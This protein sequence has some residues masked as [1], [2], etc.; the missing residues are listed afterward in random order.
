LQWTQEIIKSR[1]VLKR[2]YV[3]TRY[4]EATMG[5]VVKRIDFVEMSGT[6]V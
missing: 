4:I 1:S 3:Q 5:D 2:V 6:V